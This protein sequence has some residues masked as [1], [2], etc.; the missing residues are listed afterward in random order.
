MSPTAIVEFNNVGKTYWT[1]WR[2]K[3]PIQA[4]SNISFTIEPG[5]IFGLLGP[6]RAGKTT[7]IKIL[8]SLCEPTTGQ[9]FRFGQPLTDHATLGRIGYMHEQHA[10]PRYLTAKEVL[11]YYGA[12]S[13]VP[14]AEL[15]RRVSTLLDRVGLT[16][17]AT[18]AV[19]KFSKG[20]TQRLALAQALI[21]EPELLVL[22]EPSEGLDLDGRRLL[23]EVIAE[24]RKQKRT[25]LLVTHVLTEAEKV[26]DRV[27][28]LVDGR[29][30]H[31][32]PTAQLTQTAAGT[33]RPIEHA[34]QEI[35]QARASA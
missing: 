15:S 22:D 10:L 16:N 27:A 5:E 7:L 19:S 33:L 18:V 24:Q 4:A 21:N 20:M 2:K 26:C 32:G 6:N 9:A 34:L 13:L 29:I 8:L 17:F 12:L 1:G 25:V 35:Y 28:V 31:L 23:R 30:V 14:Q 11:E 3:R